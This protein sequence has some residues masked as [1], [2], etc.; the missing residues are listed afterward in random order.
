MC[1]W[2]DKFYKFFVTW[3][4]FEVIYMDAERQSIC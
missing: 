4:S 2:T 3:F 1:K